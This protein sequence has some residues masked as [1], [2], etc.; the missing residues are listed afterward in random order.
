M[1]EKRSSLLFTKTEKS[2]LFKVSVISLDLYWLGFD[3]GEKLMGK[4]PVTNDHVSAAVSFCE[5]MAKFSVDVNRLLTKQVIPH[6]VSMP[7][8][9]IRDFFVFV[10]LVPVQKDLDANVLF[11]KQHSSMASKLDH[12]GQIFE[13]GNLIGPWQSK[14]MLIMFHCTNICR[15][16]HESILYLETYQRKSIIAAVGSEVS[17]KS[18]MEC[19]HFVNKEHFQAFSHCIRENNHRNS[20]SMV[21]IVQDM[22][23]IKTV[24]VSKEQDSLNVPI[25]P[26]FKLKINGTVEKSKWNGLYFFGEQY[27]YLQLDLRSQL[28]GQSIVLIG[29]MA[30]EKNFNLEFACYLKDRDSFEIPLDLNVLPSQKTFAEQVSSLSD[31]QEAFCTLYRDYELSSKSVF[32]VVCIPLKGLLEKALNLKNESLLKEIEIS[33]DVFHWLTEFNV[34]ID[35]L[36]YKGDKNDF[37]N[38]IDLSYSLYRLDR[39]LWHEKQKNNIVSIIMHDD[40]HSLKFRIGDV[41]TF[42]DEINNETPFHLAVW[43]NAVDCMKEIVT[44]AKKC[45]MMNVENSIGATVLHYALALKSKP[46]IR[47]LLRHGA[48]PFHVSSKGYPTPYEFASEDEELKLMLSRASMNVVDFARQNDLKAVIERMETGGDPD[49]REEGTRNTSLFWAALN[50]NRQMMFYLVERGA[51]VN[52][53]NRE[54]DTPL[55]VVISQGKENMAIWLVKHGAD[56]FLENK[57]TVSPYDMASDSFKQELKKCA[58]DVGE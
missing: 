44:M 28:F 35:L 14:L 11:E 52:R 58:A 45:N 54:G 22:E 4:T 17:L 8:S 21:S 9:S 29:R 31:V 19:L 49:A 36:E 26:S 6:D 10:P 55:H 43:I 51:D 56:I 20:D 1:F 25:N 30:D 37:G 39:L 12:L 46:V 42:Y 40:A 50:E 13:R 7:F 38:V 33:N 18:L 34:P 3:S 24:V 57:R 5:A 48:N 47:F 41:F 23:P 2:P 53:Q 16:F 27:P 32:A 15:A